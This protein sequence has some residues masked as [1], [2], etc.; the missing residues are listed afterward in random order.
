MKR[1][2]L[3][4]IAVLFAYL[5]INAQK[6]EYMYPAIRLGFSNSFSG[7]PGANVQ[8]FVTEGGDSFDQI[9]V[10]PVGSFMGYVPGVK[11]SMLY[12]FD[13][14]GDMA[15][16]FT[17]LDYNFTGISSKYE[18]VG[19]DLNMV[20]T[21][22]MHMVGIPLAIKYGPDIWDTQRYGYLG[23]QLN[24]IASMYTSEKT[25]FGKKGSRKLEADEFNKM[26]FSI[27]AGVNWKIINFQIDF[28]P[29][30]IFNKGYKLIDERTK[31]KDG[32]N[33]SIYKKKDGKQETVLF[34]MPNEGQV[35]TFVK[36]TISV[37]LPYG[38]LSEQ[39]FKMRRALLKWPWK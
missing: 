8:K 4:T 13:F 5:S 7:Q 25:N 19:R 11:L 29:K 35:E 9:A 33:L 14:A 2:I 32:T 23:V 20:E 26:V 16:I 15:G 38:W 36:F 39:S 21:H 6:N 17:G 10:T 30:S 34:S 1:Y 18:A 22:R 12:H 3:L 24:Y 28:Y 37:N 27:F 31:P